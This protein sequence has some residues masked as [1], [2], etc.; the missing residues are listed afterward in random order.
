LD[1]G[2]SSASL[3]RLAWSLLVFKKLPNFVAP[4]LVCLLVV[5]LVLIGIVSMVRLINQEI[6]ERKCRPTACQPNVISSCRC[7][8]QQSMRIVDGLV[9]CECPSDVEA[10][11][12]DTGADTDPP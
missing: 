4:L 3:S 7:T 8:E 12:D 1:P 2:A 6:R 5:G 11:D 9:V 10:P